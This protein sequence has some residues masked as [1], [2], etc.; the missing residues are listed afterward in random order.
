MKCA[1]TATAISEGFRD[2]G[3]RVVL[4]LDSITRFARAAREV[5]LA[6]GEPA[7]RRGFP[8]SV[9]AA[10][11]ALLERSG[12]APRGSITAFYAV[13]VEGDDLD[14]PIADEIR[15]I[16]DGH[17]VLSRKLGERGRWPAID[18][19]G[20]L[21]RVMGQVVDKSHLAAAQKVREHLAIY[22]A[23]RDLIAL[24]AYKR[25][26]DIRLEAALDR[27]D[28]IEAFLRQS[29]TESSDPSETISRLK[30]LA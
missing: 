24:G 22:E 9:F 12:T 26:S 30:A 8:P 4:L 7:A 3:L 11:P 20:S 14:E 27:V 6:A 18:V 10:L 1:Y 17:I 25:G 19:L 23:S 29:T 16:L 2:Q 13:L 28:G 21:S 5:G 15:G